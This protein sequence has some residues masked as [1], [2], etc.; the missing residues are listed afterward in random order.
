METYY[1]V[2]LYAV[3]CFVA[4]IWGEYRYR[5]GV[6]DGNELLNI[7]DKFKKEMAQMMWEEQVHGSRQMISLLK[8][9]KIIRIDEDTGTVYGIA[10]SSYNVSQELDMEARKKD[11]KSHSG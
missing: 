5:K 9:K 3:L 4:G 6:Q 1:F 10:D 2:G 7:S 8:S 11:E